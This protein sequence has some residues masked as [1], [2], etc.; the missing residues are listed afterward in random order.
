VTELICGS[1]VWRQIN[2]AARGA[3][4]RRTAAVA[5]LGVDAP[6]LLSA[7]GAGDVIVCDAS[8]RVLRN[9][10]THPAALAALLRRKVRL[11]SK[12]GLHAKVFA[13][14]DL[15]IVG[16]ANAS[17]SSAGSLIEAM[18]RTRDR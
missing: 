5:Y 14:V 2:D 6:A 15:A 11:V 12:E 4:G 9:G 13:L 18:V 1:E 10:G 17:A 16:S 3:R 8:R 7:F